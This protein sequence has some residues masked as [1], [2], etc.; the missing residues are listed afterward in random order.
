MPPAQ[1]LFSVWKKVFSYT[2]YTRNAGK[3][4]PVRG[5]YKKKCSEK[6]LTNRIGKL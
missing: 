6:G 4:L 5:L 3:F 2:K 1:L